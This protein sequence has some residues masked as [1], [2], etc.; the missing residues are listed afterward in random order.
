MIKYYLQHKAQR[1]QSEGEKKIA[2]LQIAGQERALTAAKKLKNNKS[3]YDY[4]SNKALTLYK[5]E[6][7]KEKFIN[8]FNKN[9]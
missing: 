8:I 5:E 4:C 7:T 3:F 2:D 1:T 6:F 9:Y